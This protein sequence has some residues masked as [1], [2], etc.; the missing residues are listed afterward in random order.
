MPR[1]ADLKKNATLPLQR[2]LAVIQPAG[3]MHGPKRVNERF[4][5]QALQ[6]VRDGF[7]ANGQAHYFKCKPASTSPRGF[8]A[9]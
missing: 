4:G 5:I 1:A 8:I 3:E 2:D 9:T 7:I 6:T